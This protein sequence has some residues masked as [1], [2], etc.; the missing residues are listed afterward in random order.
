MSGA[1]TSALFVVR[2]PEVIAKGQKKSERPPR[3][4]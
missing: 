4:A 1:G 3:I 2:I